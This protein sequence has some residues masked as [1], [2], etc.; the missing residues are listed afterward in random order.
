[1][2]EIAKRNDTVRFVKL[3]GHDAELDPDVLPAVLAYKGGQKLVTLLPLL[4]ALPVDSETSTLS[5]ET[6]LRR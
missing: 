5:I 4:D 6:C 2:H 1:M 3:H